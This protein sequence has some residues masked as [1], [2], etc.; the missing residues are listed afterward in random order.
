LLFK[1]NAIAQAFDYV[2]GLNAADHRIEIITMS[3]GGLASQTWA[4]AVNALYEQGVFIVRGAGNNFGNLPTRNSCFRPASAAWSPCGVM[5]NGALSQS[6]IVESVMPEHPATATPPSTGAWPK[7]WPRTK[8][9]K[10]ATPSPR[11]GG[12]RLPTDRTIGDASR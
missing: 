6:G 7:R 9:I 10:A 12:R 4:E 2:H 11:R 5:A 1:N 8:G 3:M